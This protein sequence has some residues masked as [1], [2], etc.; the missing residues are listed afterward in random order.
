MVHC[1]D[2]RCLLAFLFKFIWF[3]L[4]YLSIYLYWYG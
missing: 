2:S 4:Y 3:Y 1:F